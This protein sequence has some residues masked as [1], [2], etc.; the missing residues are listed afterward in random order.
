MR[1]FH[2]FAFGS[3]LSVP[4][5]RARCPSATPLATG[6]VRGRQLR[7]HKIGRDGTGKADAY[8]TGNPEDI[9]RGVI[10]RCE[11]DDK[12][13]LDRCECLGDGYEEVSVEVQVGE[14]VW[15]TFLYE[16]MSHRIDIEIRPAAWYHNHVIAGA[17]E[18][19]LPALYQEMIAGF[20][21]LEDQAALSKVNRLMPCDARR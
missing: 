8:F 14:R 10:Y 1:T 4:R 9:V 16:A 19:A 3:N 18:H 7:F 5:L 21:T 17:R 12:H 20:Q 2:H 11:L 6:F 15:T 13:E